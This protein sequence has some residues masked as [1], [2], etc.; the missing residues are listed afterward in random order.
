MDLYVTTLGNKTHHLYVNYGGHFKEEADIRGVALEQPSGRSLGG[1]TPAIGD[2]N[3]DG[4][5]DIYASEW[6]ISS[7]GKVTMCFALQSKK[8]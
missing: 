3:N 1:M 5:P 8:F 7:K 6:I 2:F 4:Y